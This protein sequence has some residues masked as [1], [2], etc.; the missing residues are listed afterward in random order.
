MKKL[1]RRKRDFSK[2]IYLYNLIFVTCIVITSFVLM[3]LSG[4]LGVMDLSAIQVIV[5]AAFAE[6]GLHT[7]FYIWKAKIENCRKYLSAAEELEELKRIE[8]GLERMENESYVDSGQ[9]TDISYR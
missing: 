3:F 9:N 2:S 5:P 8:A 1:S 7:A 6:L 4:K